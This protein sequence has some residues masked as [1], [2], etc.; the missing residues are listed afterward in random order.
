M[1]SERLK[2]STDAYIQYISD[3][4][5]WSGANVMYSVDSI[6]SDI[7]EVRLLV[8]DSNDALVL[9]SNFSYLYDGV[10]TNITKSTDSLGRMIVVT[11]LIALN[12]ESV[13]N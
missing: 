10:Y 3:Y 7:V 9:G 12:E 5:D 13:N 6:G 8:S 4:C 11:S 1:I 2:Q